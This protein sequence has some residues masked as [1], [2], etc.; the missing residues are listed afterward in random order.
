MMIIV[1]YV[2]NNVILM[3]TNINQNIHNLNK[4]FMNVQQIVININN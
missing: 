4:L 3:N 2:F 1:N